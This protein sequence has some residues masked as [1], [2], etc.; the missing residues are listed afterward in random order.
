MTRVRRVVLFVVLSAGFL[1]STE[2]ASCQ[3]VGSQQTQRQQLRVVLYPFIPEFTYAAE[4]V[5]RLFEAE[6]PDVELV[7]LDLSDNYYA[8]PKPGKHD[9]TYIGEVDTDVYELDSVF[10]ADFVK[11][12]KIQPLKDDILLSEGALLKNAYVGSMLDGVRY[13]SPHWVCGD[14]LFYRNNN[15]KEKDNAPAGDIKTL[16]D[17]E[18]FV[19]SD[20]KFRLL[21]DMRGRLTLGEFYLATAYAKYKD[22]A[23]V[24]QHIDPADESLEADLVR[25]LKLCPTGSCR[26]LVFHEITGIYG[27]EFAQKRSKALIGYSELLHSVLKEGINNGTISDKDLAVAALPLD[28]AGAVPISWVD[29][30]AVQKDC[31]DDCYQRAAKFIKFMQRDD[32]YLKLL[33]PDRPSFIH[34]PAGPFPIP[35][36]LLPAKGSLYTNS[37]LISAAHLYP[38]LRKIIEAALVPTAIG[39]NQDLRKVSSSVDDALNKAV[40]Q[41]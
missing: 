35:A 3:S 17:L 27:Q 9:P 13:G 5:K 29:S 1:A 32:V 25:V 37:T 31:R 23:Q 34:N 41:Q 26:D 19:G 14:F 36:Y 22:P 6:N 12:H 15:D 33:L 21:V 18:D 38:D 20:L 4:A 11:D 10:L 30:F 16:K 24:K 2:S 39:L 8:P 28:D 7:V 40:P